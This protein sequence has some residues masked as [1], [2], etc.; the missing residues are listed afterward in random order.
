MQTL[1]R[2]DAQLEVQSAPVEREMKM[3]FE[4]VAILSVSHIEA[5]NRIL[6]EELEVQLAQNLERFGMRPALIR[7]L[8]GIFERRL[9]DPGIQP[10]DAAT[11]AAELAL[12]E[13]GI[14][15]NE[16]GVLINTSVSKDYIEPSVASLVHGNLGLPA[17][18]MNFDVSNACLGFVNGIAIAGN[19]IDRGQI[20]YAIIVNGENSREAME[21]TLK[22]LTD[23]N[24]DEQT[25][26]ESYATLTLGSGAAAMVLG[27]ADKHPEGHRVIG[28]VSYAATQHN[29]L[30]VGQMNWMKT[31]A[32]ALLK[33]GIELVM[34][35]YP[36]FLQVIQSVSDDIDH[37]VF[38]QVSHPHTEKTV[39]L[40][41]IDGSKVYRVYR[42]FGNTGPVGIPM[43][44]SKS[45]REGKVKRGDRVALFGV[46]S[47]INCF[48][49]AVD[50]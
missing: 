31:D 15:R 34:K 19:M 3:L 32:S 6:S 4:N 18:C 25:F 14:D 21:G 2:P 36:R 43:V 41:G 26:R 45:V 39:Q 24:V 40:L 50:W 9:W 8:S 11:M 10:S 5:P 48:M 44:L 17:H 16:M 46:G 12:A 37:F 7:E 47:G 1:T 13:S 23:P 49:M 20:E 42:E 22:R 38:H 33:A 29:R 35:T 28:G 27:P 30:C